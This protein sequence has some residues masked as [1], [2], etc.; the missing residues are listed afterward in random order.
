MISRKTNDA[1]IETLELP[2]GSTAHLPTAEEGKTVT[3]TLTYTFSGDPVTNGVIHDHVPQGLA[4]VAGSATSDDQFTFVGYDA[5]TRT[6]TWTAASVTKSGSLTYQALVQ[7]GASELPQPLHNVATIK[8]D[9][10][11]LDDA[12][13]DVYVP[14]IPAGE[15]N[16]PTAPPT[17]TV[18]D[19]GQ[20]DAGNSLTL[21]LV[22][23]GA[24]VMGIAFITPVPARRR[25]RR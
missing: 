15:T 19:G 18:A 25:N 21:I 6:L 1:P 16:V 23:L 7:T 11:K 20:G 9:Q 12:A 4:Y 2:D 24:L 5:G 22:V 14:V 10:T 3:Y 17:D 8:S 13:S